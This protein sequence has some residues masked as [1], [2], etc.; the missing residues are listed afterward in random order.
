MLNE[1][2]KMVR[3]QA[4]LKSIKV[5]L[6]I[7]NDIPEYIT[8]DENRIRQIILNLIQN[9]LKFT[10]KGSIKIN[11]S[12]SDQD[13][14]LLAIRDTGIGIKPHNLGKLCTAFG[15]IDLE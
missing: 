12:Y 9:A 2:Y 7:E 15:K 3:Q 11:C 1:V 8:S 6:N 13:K 14:I 5:E 4:I 10:H